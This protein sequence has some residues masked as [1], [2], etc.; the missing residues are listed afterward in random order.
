MKQALTHAGCVVFRKDGEETFFL[1]ISSSSGKHWVLPKGHIEENESPE[2]AALRELKEEAGIKGQIVEPLSIRKYKKGKEN[3]TVQYFLVRM[4]EVQK[5]REG[6][7]LRWENK[8]SA[9][10][11]LSFDEA[12]SAF[13]EAM[14]ATRRNP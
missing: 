13:Q 5:S 6:R 2:A 4:T 7:V 1:V 3:V 12:K 9:L 14:T 10:N 11:L 8:D